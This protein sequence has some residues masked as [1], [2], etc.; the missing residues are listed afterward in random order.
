MIVP[1]HAFLTRSLKSCYF[2][3]AKVP[4]VNYKRF[5]SV[6][7]TGEQSCISVILYRV[8]GITL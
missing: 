6:F 4:V 1:L 2:L 7:Y 5:Q 3:M 8:S